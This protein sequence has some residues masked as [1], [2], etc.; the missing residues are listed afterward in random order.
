MCL[1]I[2]MKVID[3]DETFGVVEFG[4]V[5][6]R[7]SLVLC[8]GAQVG[9]HVLI[10]AGFAIAEID[11]A[12]AAETVRLFEEIAAAERDQ[13]ADAQAKGETEA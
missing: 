9:G 6:R 11:E 5:H 13:D 1:A 2:P 7:V 3:R 12:E 4:G 8:P 10:H